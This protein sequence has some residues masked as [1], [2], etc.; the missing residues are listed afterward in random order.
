LK[1]ANGLNY[2]FSRIVSYTDIMD[3]IINQQQDQ[4]HAKI[5]DVHIDKWSK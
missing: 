5:P 1:G 3:N 2:C 4:F